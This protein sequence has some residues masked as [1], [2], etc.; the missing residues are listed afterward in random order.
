MVGDTMKI[1]YGTVDARPE[2]VGYNPETLSVL[3]GHFQRLI[4]EKKIQAAAYLLSRGGK[5]FAHASMGAL[6]FEDGSG[7]FMPDS[8]RQIASLSKMF[9][10]TAILQLMEHG[11]IYL[12]QPACSI[13]KEMDT[14]MHRRITIFHMLTHTSGLKAEPGS[15]MEPY[16]EDLWG[17]LTKD[18]WIRKFLEGPLQYKTGTTWN[19][20]SKNYSLLA[21]IVSRASGMDFTDYVQENIIQPLGLKDT[22]FFVPKERLPEVCVVSK[23]NK[24]ELSWER[25]KM[26]S[27]SLKGPGGIVSTVTD[28]WKLGQMMLNGGSFNGTRI[29]GRKTVEAAVKLQIDKFP[30]HNWRVN[31]FDET[32]CRSCGLGW[33]V[34]YHSFLPDGT[35]AHEGAGGIGLYMDPKNDFIFSGFYPGENYCADS[36]VSTLAVAWSGIL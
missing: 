16:P 33:E 9:T 6:S 35:F 4:A 30:A 5:R 12:S 11:T 10:A 3:N 15:Y 14:E 18:N 32:Y 19:Y 21:E 17:S 28:A 23:W 22:Y 13:I 27:T 20:C 29:L 36:W 34:N 31:R 25:R 24:R 7:D 8:L 1:H 26:A 2:D